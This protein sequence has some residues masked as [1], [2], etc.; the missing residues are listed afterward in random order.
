M[1]IGILTFLEQQNYGG[2]LQ[3][4]ALQHALSIDGY[5]ADSVRFW[6]T[7]NNSFL[8][9]YFQKRN[10]SFLRRSYHLARHWLKHDLIFCD[11]LRRKRTID[12]IRKHIGISER[13]YKN[14]NELREQTDFQTLLVGS[15]Q[16][17]NPTWKFTAPF[18]LDEQKHPVK[19]LAYAASFGVPSIPQEQ[20]ERYS[21]A[22]RDF[23]AI[24]CREENGCAIV[25]QLTGKRPEW[26]MDPVQLLPA[27]EWR[28]LVPVKSTCEDYLFCYWLGDVQQIYQFLR[29]NCVDKRVMLC[30]KNPNEK[31]L[32]AGAFAQTIQNCP[33]HVT[34]CLTSGPLEFLELLANASEVVS[35][36]FH[37]MM[38]SLIFEKR[39]RI[40]TQSDSSRAGMTDRMTSF[41]QRIEL[42]DC[43]SEQLEYKPCVLPDYTN[44]LPKLD[45]WR[46]S[47]RTWLHDALGQPT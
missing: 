17:W 34:L 9:G 43:I 13:E 30:I 3:A 26:V 24:S 40:Y 41:A 12:F 39:F 7:K 35:D 33:H 42:L 8:Y 28:K 15:D 5:E 23:A 25:E 20:A 37:A 18:L 29:E 38:F 10:D 6:Y 27:K 1:K 47:S 4:Y 16:I 11:Y 14:A 45:A 21:Q 32:Y 22:L 46:Q 36:S 2:V 31:E 44:I 19:K